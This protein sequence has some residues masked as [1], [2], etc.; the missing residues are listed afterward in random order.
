MKKSFIFTLIIFLG[1]NILSKSQIVTLFTMPDSLIIMAFFD[2]MDGKTYYIPSSNLI[3]YNDE[4]HKGFNIH[5][6]INPEDKKVSG[7]SVKM[8]NIG[9][10][11]E[12]NELI[13]LFEDDS[14]II[15]KSWNEF[16][17]EGK[18]YFSISKVELR[19]LSSKKIRKIRVTNGCS[20]DSYTSDVEQKDQSY[21]IKYFRM[22]KNE[23]IF[24]YK[25]I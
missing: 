18:A 11:V 20:G 19:K 25:E 14:K 23:Q 1:V 5:P 4:I 21:F 24:E 6:L 12:N 13:I 15:L 8:K 3:C 16:N 22:L 2:E 7:L 10:C 17:C 9:K